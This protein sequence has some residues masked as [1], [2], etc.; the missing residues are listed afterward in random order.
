MIIR[1]VNSKREVKLKF[2]L[3]HKLDSDRINILNL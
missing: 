2:Y 1:S 3:D